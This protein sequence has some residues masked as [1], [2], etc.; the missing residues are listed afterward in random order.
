MTRKST[1]W[2]TIASSEITP[3]AVWLNRRILMKA[4]AAG[5]LAGGLPQGALA[6]PRDLPALS[7]KQSECDGCRAS[8]ALTP[9]EDATNYNNF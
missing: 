4:A 1:S 8:D 2:P 3:E 6:V 9:Y 5:A 7:A